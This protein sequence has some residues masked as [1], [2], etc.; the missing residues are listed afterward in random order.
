MSVEPLQTQQVPIFEITTYPNV[1]IDV[2]P[3]P[4]GNVLLIVDVPTPIGVSKRMVFP[5]GVPYAEGLGKKLTAPRI[6]VATPGMVN[7][8][9]Q[10]H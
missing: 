2:Q 8:N 10:V 3:D 9:G 1:S 5:M 4:S 7:G 6:Q